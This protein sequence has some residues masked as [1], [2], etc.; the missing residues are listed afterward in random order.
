M[1]LVRTLE[2]T[3]EALRED[4]RSVLSHN[5]YLYTSWF[6][7]IPTRRRL[8]GSLRVYLPSVLTKTEEALRRDVRAYLGELA[9]S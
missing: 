9:S 7:R 8:G 4:V 5:I 6:C 2:R 3:E 1:T